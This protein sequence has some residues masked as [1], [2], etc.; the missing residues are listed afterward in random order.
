MITVIPAAGKSSRYFGDKPKWLRTLPNGKIM[1][2]EAI[3]DLI[4][5]SESVYLITTLELEES[6]DV[7]TLI[8]QIFNDK[9]EVVLLENQTSS[10]VET[11]LEGLMLIKPNLE[12]KLL[13]KDSDN[14][15]DFDL[16]SVEPPFSVGVDIAD[17]TVERVYNKSF[18][19]LEDDLIIDFIEKQVISKYISVG[20]H[21]FG[22]VS[23]FLDSAANLLST[24]NPVNEFY[25]SNVV[26]SMIYSGVQV[27]YIEAQRY[28]DL[29]TQKE[30]EEM[31]GKASTFFIDY[32]GTLVKNVGKYG[33]QRWGDK[34][35]PLED[36]LRLCK[37]LFDSGAQIIITTSRS[38]SN[39]EGIKDLLEQ[40]GIIPHA[41]ITDLNHSCRILINDYA[42]TNLY[43]SA[44]AV[45]LERNG[46]LI[47]FFPQFKL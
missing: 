7:K 8:S 2:E 38:H 10:A 29:G 30:W 22:S 23:Q 47:N 20:T 25:I 31:R 33:R 41:V 27:R 32:D 26:A 44:K 42:S 1:I 4:H 11:V 35:E 15:V 34:D 14:I 40:Y 37:K 5:Y 45:N 46:S 13:I 12:E 43:P 36:N 21:G 9:V 16:D 28:L 3:G 17:F 6:Y 39:R 24:I 18:F 19:R